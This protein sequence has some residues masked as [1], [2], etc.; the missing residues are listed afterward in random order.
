MQHHSVTVG[1]DVGMGTAPDPVDRRAAAVGLLTVVAANALYLSGLPHLLDPMI[2]MDSYYIELAQQG[3]SK[4]LSKD[5]SWGPLYAL[6]LMPFV[7]VLGD[8]LLVYAANLYA[9]SLGVTV[10]LYAYVL[11]LT[12]HA[13]VAVGAALFLLISDF[14]VPLCGKASS[15]A[16]LTTLVGLAVAELTRAGARRMSVA[17]TAVL[18]ASY[19]RPELFAAAVLLYLVALWRGYRESTAADRRVLCW[20]LGGLLAILILAVWVGT[21]L[22]SPYHSSDRLLMAFREHFAWNWA[23]WHQEWRYWITIWEQELGGA[24]SIPQAFLVNPLAVMHHLGDNLAGTVTF[25]INTAFRHYPVLAPA[26]HTAL[27]QAESILAALAILGSLPLVAIRPDLR[28]RLVERHGD[29]LA[30][31]GVLALFPMASAILI[32]P[33]PNYLLLPSV[34]ALLVAALAAT[35]FLPSLPAFSWR[36]AVSACLL[37]LIAVPRPFVLPS[38]Y[39]VPGSPFQATITTARPTTDLILFIRSLPLPRPLQV[40]TVSDGIGDMLGPG[41]REIKMWQKGEQPLAD[42]LR[43]NDVGLIVKLGEGE[44]TFNVNDPYW[45]K[46]LTTPEETGFTR[47]PMPSYDKVRVYARTDLLSRATP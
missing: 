4:V 37:C 19:A 36:T 28:A 32:F 39:S 16:L 34:L 10:A 8:P 2:S 31:Y 18:V 47:M 11:L 45:G 46:I 25:M 33:L 12:R 44:D 3:V 43:T 42:Y 6:W 9:L 17:A 29:S 26:T 41:F 15:F 5:P 14:N 21:P 7:T 35:V 40:L 24:T 13:I 27:V 20:P 38:A 22:F 1:D 23:R 30:Q